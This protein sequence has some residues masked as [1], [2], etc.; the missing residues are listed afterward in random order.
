MPFGAAAH[1]ANRERTLFG[2][3]VDAVAVVSPWLHSQR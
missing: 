3:R 2:A 1:G